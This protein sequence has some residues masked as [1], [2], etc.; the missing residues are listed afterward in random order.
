MNSGSGAQTTGREKSLS[1]CAVAF[2]PGLAVPF[3]CVKNTLCANAFD[4]Q[5][6]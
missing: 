2:V 6:L 3:Q 1:Y 5:A 4:Y